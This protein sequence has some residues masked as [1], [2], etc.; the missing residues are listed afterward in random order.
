MPDLRFKVESAN[1]VPYAA[2]PMLAFQLQIENVMPGEKIHTI[3]LR[4]QIQIEVTRRRYAP[5]EQE[6]MLDLFGAP[7][8][9]SQTLRSML[10]TNASVVVPGFEGTTTVADLQVPCTF[11]FNIAATKYFEGLTDGDIPINLLFSGTVFYAP[12]ESDL[13]VAPI[14][15]EQEARY[16]LP[17]KLWREMMEVYYPNCAWINLRRDIFDRLYRYKMQHGIP[18]WEQALEKLTAQVLDSE[19]V[20]NS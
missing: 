8:R 18:T 12:P 3:A 1:V 10:W 13:Q 9:W 16:K 20:V 11:D 19:E 14:S 5:E 2:A 17:V 6:K 4:A 7:D 15:W